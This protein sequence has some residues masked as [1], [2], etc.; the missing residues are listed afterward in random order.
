MASTSVLARPERRRAL[1][2]RVTNH[3]DV[4]LLGAVLAV[5]GLSLLLIYSA[6]RS[7]LE[8]AG[9][10][11]LYFVKRQAV[12]IVLG[13]IVMVAVTLIDYR[14]YRDR[15]AIIYGGL[16]VLL[17]AVL[18]PLGSSSKGTQGWFQLPGGFQIQPSEL[19]KVLLIVA[20]AGYLAQHRGDLDAKRLAITCGLAG[21]PLALVMLQPDF[22][23][24]IVM[25]VIVVAMLAVAGV[26]GRH[27]AIITIVAMV[28]VVGVVQVGL[29]KQYQV[30]RL[31]SFIDQS[32]DKSGATYNLDQSKTAIGNGGVVGRGLFAGSQTSGSFVPEQ[33]TDFIFTVVGE[34]LGFLG[35]A[36]LLALFGIIVWRIWRIAQ[37]SADMSGTLICVGV[38]AL[39]AVH[40][41]ENVG[42]TMG[43]MPITGIPLTFVSYGGSSTIG[44]FAAIGLVLNVHLHRFE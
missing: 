20:L 5:A 2:E 30:D 14:K 31:T 11:P 40:V 42:M 13:L 6:T 36:T 32:K 26:R 33:H 41:F 10:D 19:C 27:L 4:V 18:S 43:I 7:R 1:I 15:G 44:S 28:G 29:L 12:F 17:L 3:L 25:T 9:D 37:E 24:A 16:V 39:V 35:G 38:L 34:E 21:V 22:G 23:T 8:R